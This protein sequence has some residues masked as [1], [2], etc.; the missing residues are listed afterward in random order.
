M[1]IIDI[2]GC[3]RR[4]YKGMHQAGVKDLTRRMF[5]EGEHVTMHAVKKGSTRHDEAD[6]GE[7]VAMREGLG[8]A[9]RSEQLNR[10][11]HCS[12]VSE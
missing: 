8:H 12:V 11:G 9:G 3:L 5:R 2:D 10:C 6:K 1:A 7:R 4:V